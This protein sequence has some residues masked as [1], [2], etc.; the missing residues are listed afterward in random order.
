MSG[1]N[2]FDRTVLN[3]RERPLSSDINQAQS[4]LDYT[5]RFLD[6]I[7]YEVRSTIAPGAGGSIVQGFS[8]SSFALQP[9][10]GFQVIVTGGWGFMTNFS[11]TPSAINGIV[12]LDDMSPYKPLLLLN[13]QAFTVPASDPSNPRI[14]IVEVQYNRAVTNPQSRDVLNTATGQFN[15]STVNKTLSFDLDGLTGQGSG[16]ASAPIYYKIGTASGSPTPPATDAGY[17]KV[18]EIYVPAASSGSI[19]PT[20]LHD[21]RSLLFSGGRSTATVSVQILISTG[22][23]SNFIF[24]GPPGVNCFVQP[25]TASGLK[26]ALFTFWG[27]NRQM[28]ADGATLAPANVSVFD[29]TSGPTLPTYYGASAGGGAQWFTGIGSAPVAGSL[30]L[31]ATGVPHGQEAITLGIYPLTD[32]GGPTQT[33]S[34]NI[35]VSV[36]ITS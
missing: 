28:I 16:A 1:N 3:V 15:P 34:Y 12:G 13:G 20:Y 7:G 17:V 30:P 4:Q 8:G 18:G 35:T 25:T 14:D 11:D 6:E 2:P 33:T 22:A 21:T 10:T 29:D 5:G 24:S 32:S 27:G 23:L 19:L 31:G 9:G 36:P 26:G